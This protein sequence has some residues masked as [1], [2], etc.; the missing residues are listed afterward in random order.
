M[1]CRKL[2]KSLSSPYLRQIM[3]NLRSKYNFKKPRKSCY[4]HILLF[5][6]H[7]KGSMFTLSVGLLVKSG[8]HISIRPCAINPLPPRASWGILPRYFAPYPFLEASFKNFLALIVISKFLL[9]SC[10]L[11]QTGSV[12]H[13]N[14]I[15]TS[16]FLEKQKLWIKFL[17]KNSEG[18]KKIKTSQN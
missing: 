1:G 4:S 8:R 9:C 2:K 14:C 5:I 7:N 3:L 17:K 16:C 11:R 10:N 18:G 13:S 15:L 6:T 12:T